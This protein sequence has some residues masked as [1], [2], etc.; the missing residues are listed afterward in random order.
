MKVDDFLKVDGFKE[1]MATKL[2]NGI[3]EKLEKANIV[4]LMSAS[5]IFGRGFS[6]KK[7][8]LIVHSYPD[9]LVSKESNPQKIA[10]IAAIKGMAT[11]TSEAFVEKITEF[12]K[13]IQE[14]GIDKILTTTP[15]TKNSVCSDS[16]LSR[17]SVVLSGFRDVDIQEKIKNL[18]GKLGTSVSKNTFIVLVKDKEEVTGK[19]EDAKKL[20]VCI[21]DVD[22]FKDKY[23]I[24]I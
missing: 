14:A 6:E 3:R 21:M 4:T 16:P 15:G 10:K 8:E 13:F 18:G 12:V 20:G 5:N 7:L 19:V 23:I 1:K 24:N 11:K 2:C 22:E 17:K 9:V